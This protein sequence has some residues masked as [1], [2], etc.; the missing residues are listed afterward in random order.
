VRAAG[1]IAKAAPKRFVAPWLLVTGYDG[2]AM[3][4][5]GLWDL[6]SGAKLPI[7][8]SILICPACLFAQ[9]AVAKIP[10]LI[11]PLRVGSSNDR[12][13][14]TRCCGLWVGGVRDSDP[15]RCPSN[16]NGGKRYGLF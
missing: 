4:W 16:E 5:C 13:F 12:Q 15:F 10:F 3:L 14:S 9:K 8:S 1:L 11:S 7:I 6:G 2:T